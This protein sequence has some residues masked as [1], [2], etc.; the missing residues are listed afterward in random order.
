MDNN[1]VTNTS[2]KANGTAVES[3]GAITEAGE[4][5]APSG[6][7][8]TGFRIDWVRKLSSRKFWAC[9]CGFVTPLLT[10]FRFSDSDIALVVSIVSSAGCL[11]AYILSEGYIDAKAAVSGNAPAGN[12]GPYLR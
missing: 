9:I 12:S 7:A 5:G 2:E 3:G 6:P 1:I 4:A 8:G 10:A 11:V